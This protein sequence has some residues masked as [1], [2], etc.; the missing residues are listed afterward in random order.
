MKRAGCVADLETE[1]LRGRSSE[2]FRLEKLVGA[3]HYPAR[4]IKAMDIEK[5]HI[6]SLPKYQGGPSNE[7]DV[8]P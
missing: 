2:D 4:E 8:R 5:I 3:Q 1:N 7:A 6:L